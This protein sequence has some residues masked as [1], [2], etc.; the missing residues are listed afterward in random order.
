LGAGKVK[1][2][3]R[4]DTKQGNR[5]LLAACCVLLVGCESQLNV[6]R[7]GFNEV[8]GKASVVETAVNVERLETL[9]SRELIHRRLS[10]QRHAAWQIMHG[11]LAYGKELPIESEGNSVN[12][13]SH[14]LEGGQMQ[15]WDLYPGDVIPTTG[16]R[17]VVARLSES[18]YFGQGHI[19][20]WLAIFAQQRIPKE[21][22]IR[23]GEDVFTLE[24]WLRQSQWD[25]SRN[26]TAEYSWTLIALTYYFPNERVWTA[27]DGKEW[28]WETLVEFELGEPLVSSACG[29]SHRLEALAMALETH[30][31]TGGKLEGVWLKTQQRLESEVNKV[32][33]WQNMDGSLSSHFF[34]RPGTTS[35]LVQRLSSSGHLFEFAAIA[36]PADKLLDPWMQRAAYRMCELLDLTQSTD[37][38]CGSLYHAL[39][40]LRVYKERLQAVQRP[41]K[42]PE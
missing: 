19:D 8:K 25:V 5:L 4:F 11:F 32:R 6:D 27:R 41:S 13:L 26:Y 10:L 14:L 21:A 2:L 20:Q 1:R 31:K 34:E 30:L 36:S 28:N 17:G 42:D 22:T 35:D 3:H 7:V 23:I 15:G 38:E 24:D 40:G 37:L 16:R 12:L 9:L 39:N 29:G 18:D 33:T